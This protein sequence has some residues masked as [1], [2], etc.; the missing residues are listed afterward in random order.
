MEEK[1]DFSLPG[2]KQKA[3]P[4]AKITIL[5][6]LILI[7]LAVANLLRKTPAQ[8]AVSDEPGGV[9]RLSR[10]GSLPPNL[11]GGIYIVGRLRSGR[12]IWRRANRTML[13]VRGRCFK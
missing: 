4:A 6:L 3:G 5:L 1:L 2:K 8:R 10:A 12:T 9:F 11:V 7:G 13:S